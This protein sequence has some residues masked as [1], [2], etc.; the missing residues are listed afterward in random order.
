MPRKLAGFMLAFCITVTPCVAQ[1]T[2]ELLQKGI[3]AQETEGNLDTAIL[4]YRQIV[5]SA[6]SQRDL[7]A[8]AQFRLAQALLQKG[9][10]TSAAQEFDKLARDYSE[11]RN[12]V[13]SLSSQ[14]STK[15]GYSAV[16]ELG[17]FPY[18]KNVA[19]ALA[20]FDGGKPVKVIGKVA[21]VILVTPLSTI[22]I[23]DG[24][25]RF[26][27]LAAAAT[28]MMRQQGFTKETLKLGDT[29]EVT[30]VLSADP[31]VEDGAT[32]ARADSISAGGKVVFD[33]AS[34]KVTTTP[35]RDELTA[36]QRKLKLSQLL[37]TI[38]QVN[39]E[40]ETARSRY[41]DNSPQVQGQ[42]RRLAELQ[43]AL[44]ALKKAID[45]GN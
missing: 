21:R 35:A 7:A 20:A 42:M 41:T 31:Q 19:F 33:R 8:Q 44:A 15:R 38:D 43:A 16:A 13:S 10:L 3:F 12:L 39:V 5:N 24:T 32:V 9:D 29:V 18:A 36:D 17:K 1:T 28:E 25:S 14:A 11:Y 34:L 2:T 22:T 27:F 26:L 6:P 37:K 4:I 23:D 45:E 30:G 40:L